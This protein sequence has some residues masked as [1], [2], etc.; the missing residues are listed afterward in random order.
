MAIRH[1]AVLA[2][3][4]EERHHAI[5]DAAARL[6]S[7]A[8]ERVANVAEVADEAGLA[9][10]TVYLYF[11]SKE[12]L[13]L[14]LHER[15]VAA[16]FDAMI[17][18][19]GAPEPVTLGYMLALARRHMVDDPIYLP[20][21]TRCFGL[22]ATQMPADAAAAF[23]ERMAGRMRAAGAGL[24]RHFPV[25]PPGGGVALLR[26]SYALIIGLWQLSSAHAGQGADGAGCPAGTFD[27]ADELG[28]ALAALWD[29]TLGARASTAAATSALASGV[30]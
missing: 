25:L 16:F 28:A 2:Q 14:A 20:L 8:P 17:A 24:E 1:R 23:M 7:R 22:M 4:K 9:K 26:R 27:Y 6:M 12:E 3:D 11:P 10:G 21:A 13:L 5:L 18:R 19:L 15:N 30:R 29:G